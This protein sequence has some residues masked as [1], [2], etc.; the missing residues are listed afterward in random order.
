MKTR[1]ITAAVGIPFLIFVLVVR[2]WF[3]ELLIVALT[4]IALYECYHALTVAHFDICQIGGY[5]AAI[6]MWPLSR[7]M[8]VLDPLLLVVAAMGLSMSG[9][10]LGKKPSFPNAAASVYPLFTCL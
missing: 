9:V 7:F 1:L 6:C 2:G 3:A 5:V 4:L 10:I 8:E